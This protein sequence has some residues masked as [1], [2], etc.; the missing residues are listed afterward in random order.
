[1]DILI[2]DNWL[3][4]YLKTKAKPTELAKYL[5][6]CGPSFERIKEGK[7]GPVHSVEV[8]TNRVD[9]ASIIGIAREAHTILP[10]FGIETKLEEPK[11][12]NVE[13]RKASLSLKIETTPELTNRVIAVV[14]EV[15]N[16]E[17][18]RW[19]KDRLEDTD[20]RSLGA[21]IDITNYVMLEIG[22]PTHVF[23]YDRIKTHK[24]I[25]RNS[26]PGEKVTTLDGKTYSLQ[27][28]DVVIDDGTG[29]IIDLPGIMGT[30]NSVA[31]PETKRIIFFVDNIKPSTIRK[32]SMSQAI[33]TQAA[34][35]N[36]KGIDPEL[37]MTA[38]LRGIQLYKEIAGAKVVSNVQDN[39]PNP[40]KPKKLNVGAGFIEK[41]L[42]VTIPKKEIIT[43]LTNLGFVVSGEAENLVIQIPS[44][45]AGDVNIPEDIV[46]EVARIYGYHKLPSKLMSG[47][48]PEHPADSTFPLET[49]I[50]QTLKA[51]GGVE[52][53]TSS[54]VSK[55]KVSL[56]K[57]ANPLKLKNPLGKDSE[58]LRVSLAPSLQSA[59]GDNKRE[60]DPFHL[61]EIA[62]TYL[63][64]E[65]NLPE[66]RLMLGG[67]FSQYE[68]RTAKGIVERL[69]KELQ[70]NSS[71]KP[72]DLVGYEKG[73]TVEVAS[74]KQVLGYLGHLNGGNIYYEFQV[75]L[76]KEN[77]KDVPEYTP[78]PKN[79]PQVEDINL[80]I[81]E[82]VYLSE[83][84]GEMQNADKRA[85]SVELIDIYKGTKTLRISYLDSEKT[86]TDKEVEK[87]REKIL[88]VLKDKFQISQK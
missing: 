75:T 13:K 5:S 65:G 22:H 18:P 6:L 54:L 25:F 46:E 33:R 88:E 66:E 78:I 52:I 79:P 49:K 27:G 45:R 14:L 68:Y 35:M 55:D 9:S 60:K 30:K 24:L 56:E 47:D 12:A 39:Y 48:L 7:T 63:P 19:L 69:L 41:K 34:S 58:Y 32:T 76:L 3:R 64:Q 83:V 85:S 73:K 1:M 2:P 20:I 38:I 21:L 40:Y 70:I 84:I 81:P 37:G 77:S 29:E 44:S 50:K 59:A 26:K 53:Y 86:L 17:S 72:K 51:L 71:W 11:L 16:A 74:N 4:D 15:E 31:T 8:T 28:D 42:G 36:E 10:R 61:F 62:N 57:G 87:A 23:D 82:G 80:V 43:I 67:I